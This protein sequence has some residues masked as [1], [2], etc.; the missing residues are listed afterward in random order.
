VTLPPPSNQT[1]RASIFDIGNRRIVSPML[2][3]SKIT[4]IKPIAS[5]FK[6]LIKVTANY[7]LACL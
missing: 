2:I 1:T 5:T 3:Y 4:N 7:D 6:I